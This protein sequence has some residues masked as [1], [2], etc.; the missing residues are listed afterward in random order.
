MIKILTLDNG[1]IPGNATKWRT[2][3]LAPLRHSAVDVLCCQSIR[4]SLG[5]TGDATRLLAE[6]LG[7][8][9]SC[10]AASRHRPAS[11][12]RRV[13]GICGLAILTGPEVWML[14]SGCFPIPGERESEEGVAQFAL[15]RKNGASV[16]ILNFQ[17]AQT[18]P[19]QQL[20]LLALLSHPLLKER[21]GAVV[22]CADQQIELSPK[23][24]RAL[25]THSN[26]SL[27]RSLAA[28]PPHSD[29]GMLCLLTAR[30]ATADVIVHNAGP[31]HNVAPSNPKR[32]GQPALALEFEVQ[33]IA[34][35]HKTRKYMPL[36]FREQW[37]GGR[38][39]YRS[40][41]A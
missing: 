39:Q 4:R 31:L 38:E 32:I 16:L 18:V 5:D 24:L 29:Q 14:N 36:S 6:A 2:Q 12:G 8:T 1:A 20:Q 37:L 23:K 26:Y 35:D 27:H 21:Y 33:R 28:A 10:F 41:A 3:T 25:T 15:I 19:T 17:L 11:E 30:E 40:F 13:K 7:M 34:S 22:L 9:Y